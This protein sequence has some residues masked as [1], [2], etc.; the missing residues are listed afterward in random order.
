[1]KKNP[2]APGE[3]ARLERSLGP[4]QHPLFH[5]KVKITKKLCPGKRREGGGENDGQKGKGEKGT[6]KRWYIKS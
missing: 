2:T 1:L 6:E 4:S 5:K 3:P